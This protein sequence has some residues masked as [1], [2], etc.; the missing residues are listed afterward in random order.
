[1]R[2]EGGG[3]SPR[4]AVVRAGLERHPSVDLVAYGQDVEVEAEGED[5]FEVG[6]GE[7]GA[8]G[9]GRVVY[10]NALEE[11]RGG[12]CRE[13]GQRNAKECRFSMS[14]FWGVGGGRGERRTGWACH[15]HT[16]L[17]VLVA[18]RL[19]RGEVDVPPRCRV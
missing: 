7:D 19:H 1:M 12:R 5:V 3:N 16:H 14:L 15:T 10:H 4:Q 9:V 8:A 18:L 11:G 6:A 17:C 13:R 2:G